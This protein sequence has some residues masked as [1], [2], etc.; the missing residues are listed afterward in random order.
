VVL[1]MSSCRD[2]PIT[3][4]ARGDTV[5]LHSEY[6]STHAADDVIGIMPAY[7]HPQ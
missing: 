1:S 5:R 3:T 4:L 7:I 2:D 6:N